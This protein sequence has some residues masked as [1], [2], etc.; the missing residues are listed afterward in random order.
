MY[1]IIVTTTFYKNTNNLRFQLACNTI[2]N[3]QESG[4]PIVVVDGSPDPLIAKTFSEL[5]ANVF[6]ETIR[7]MGSSRRLAFVYALRCLWLADQKEGIIVWIEPEKDDV[8]R[9]ID[10]IVA[11][12]QSGK[13]DISIM[14]RSDKS[15]QTYPNF[16]QE[17]EKIANT[18]YEKATGRIGYDPMS[19]PVAFLV[20]V[21]QKYFLLNP[22]QYEISDTYI[23]HYIPLFI[24]ADRVASVEVDFMY[25]EVQKTAEETTEN[26]TAKDKRQWQLESLSADYHTLAQT[27]K[28]GLY[29]E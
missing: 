1:I 10:N 26:K 23:Q 3:A 24:P 22:L 27:L 12:I 25:P 6:P 9:L 28:I 8:I 16:Q 19:G 15:L 13:A 17:S 21:L 7:G 4:Y 2:R 11:P 5:G 20:S 29:A 14:K 18:A